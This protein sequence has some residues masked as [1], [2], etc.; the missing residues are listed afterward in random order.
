MWQSPINEICD[1]FHNN[2]LK[3]GFTNGCFD[4]L[5][6]GHLHLLAEA[7]T[8]CDVLIIGLNSDKSVSALKPGRPIQTWKKREKALMDSKF[9]DFVFE[10]DDEPELAALIRTIRPD[11][12][13]KGADYYG[14]RIV[15]SVY[16]RSVVLI[17]LIEGIST[18]KI[19]SMLPPR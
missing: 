16:A 12:L 6:D 1:A 5:H 14:K 18:T 17:P 8:Y 15:G 11:F 3:I 10:F 9:V 4:L 13:F 2:D 7:N 19:L